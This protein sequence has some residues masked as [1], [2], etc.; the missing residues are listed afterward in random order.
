[1]DSLKEKMREKVREIFVAGQSAG[2]HGNCC[3]SA[4]YLDIATDAILFLI[5]WRD[6]AARIL[7]LEAEVR[8]CTAER[9]RAQKACQQIVKR[10]TPRRLGYA[11]KDRVI[12][13]VERPPF[14]ETTFFYDIIWSEPRQQFV[15]PFVEALNGATH[16]L[17]PRDLIQLPPQKRRSRRKATDGVVPPKRIPD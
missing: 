13:G 7:E 17:D 16:F 4:S 8:A 3:V 12:I 10:F 14:Q 11:P 9:D 1:M 2:L 6:T 15:T 5:G